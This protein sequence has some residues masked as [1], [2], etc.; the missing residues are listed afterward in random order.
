MTGETDEVL[1]SSTS[2]AEGGGVEPQANNTP[3]PASQPAPEATT[4]P[5]VEPEATPP[6]ETPRDDRGRFAPKDEAASNPDPVEAAMDRLARGKDAPKAPDPAKAP[7][8]PTP[9]GKAP[10]KALAA[11]PGKPASEPGQQAPTKEDPFAGLPLTELK[12]KTRERIETLSKRAIEAETKLSQVQDDPIASDFA[13]ATKEYGLDADLGFVPPE[14]LASLVKVQAAINRAHLAIQQGR[15]PAQADL[16]AVSM[17]HGQVN[18]LATQF[19]AAQPPKQQ[20]HVPPISPMQG[21]LPPELEDLITVYGLP[22]ADVR[23]LAAIKAQGA[24]P[25]GK[26]PAPTSN[27]PPASQAPEQPQRP[28]GVD[29]DALYAQRLAGDMIRDG[30]P[31]KSLKSHMTAIQSFMVQ[32]VQKRFPF[33]EASRVPQVFDQL[34]PK[35]RYDIT[36]TAHRTARGK[37]A[38]PT[39]STPPP[40][41]RTAHSG[42]FPRRTAPAV[43]DDPVDDAVNRLARAPE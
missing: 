14:N 19:G 10:E 33:V 16:Q 34:D 12:A 8:K 21:Q 24:R 43:S 1:D 26:Q 40:P 9:P 4:T 32:E 38:S 23:M 27:E 7:A 11:P 35:E 6:S 28:E 42:A 36:L 39:P 30:V 3:E 29:M 17:L 25:Q 18:T 20:D 2:N 31:A 22:E 41:T 15:R 37:V 13:K 5:P